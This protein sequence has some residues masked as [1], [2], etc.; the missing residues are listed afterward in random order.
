MKADIM[1]SIFS[2][3]CFI[4]LCTSRGYSQEN[5]S[6]NL[7]EFTLNNLQL[8]DL[9]INKVTD[10]LGRPSATNSNP[11]APELVDITGAMIYYH[12]KGLKIWFYSSST[13]PLKRLW[14]VEVFLARKWD[15][16][17]KEFYYPFKGDIIPNLDGNMKSDSVCSIFKVYNPKITSAKMA[18]QKSDEDR[19]AY[20]VESYIKPS[21]LTN[22]NISVKTDKGSIYLDCEE[23]TKFLESF[24]VYTPQK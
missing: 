12:D 8:K 6:L 16:Q 10:I 22:D 17:F 1:K 23:L 18:R 11:V 20:H 9:T 5:I 13:D 15:D 3:L 4:F 7:N 21:T 24:T 19:R 14:N 2:I